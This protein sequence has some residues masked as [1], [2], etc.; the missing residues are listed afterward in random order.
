MLDEHLTGIT[1]A[2]SVSLQ[3]VAETG[4]LIEA[5]VE[6]L[7]ARHQLPHQD[8][9]LLLRQASEEMARPLQ[10]AAED[11]IRISLPASG[12]PVG[13]GIRLR[14]RAEGTGRLTLSQ[15]ETAATDRANDEAGLSVGAVAVR[16]LQLLVASDLPEELLQG[17][18]ELAVDAMPGCQWAGVRLIRDGQPALVASSDASIQAVDDLQFRTGDGPCLQ[19]VGT[20]APVYVDLVEHDDCAVDAQAWQRAA[21]KAG[22]TASMSLPLPSPSDLVA[23]LSLHSGLP[24]GWPYGART[25]AADFARQ[26]GLGRVS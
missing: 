7:M 13:S 25:A 20:S 16:L 14:S 26:V 3:V 4:D 21:K 6:I 10:E 11:V 19:A 5:A 2:P 1:P 18:S 15:N 9:A 24:T 23:V 22:I 17:I 12:T 8:A